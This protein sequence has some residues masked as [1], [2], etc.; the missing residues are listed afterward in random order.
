MRIVF[1]ISDQSTRG[2]HID[3]DGAALKPRD[4]LLGLDHQ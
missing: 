3:I 4:D 2:F 1:Q